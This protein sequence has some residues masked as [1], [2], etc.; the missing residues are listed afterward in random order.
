MSAMKG[1]NLR[2][3]KRRFE[4]KTGVDLN[5][6]YRVRRGPVRKI[7]LLAAVIV[8]CAAM[9]A[10]ASPLFTPLDGDELSLKG[11]YEGNGIV[12]V[13]VENRSDKKLEFQS[14]T[15]LMRWATSEEVESLGGEAVFEN[16]EFAP[17]SSG[18]MTVDLSRAYDVK[19]LEKSVTN[20][21]WFYLVLTN[22]DFLFGHDWMCSVNFGKTENGPLREETR[23]H[24]TAEAES[25]EEVPVQLRFYFEDAYGD[26]LFAFNEANFQY[27]QKVEEILARFPGTVVSA[28]SPDIM[29][30]MPSVFLDPEPMMGKIPGDVLFDEAVPQE[31]QYLLSWSDWTYTDGYGRMVASSDE[32]AWSQVA[33]LPQQEGQSD[34]GVALPLIF[35]FVYDADLALPENYAFIYGAFHSF[36]ELEQHLVRRDEH[37]AIYDATDL[38]YTDLDAYIDY[39]LATR[40]DVFCDESIRARV[41]RI[42]EFYQDRQQLAQLI[43][44]LE[45]EKKDPP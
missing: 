44:Y 45:L 17:H 29:V 31:Q 11:T 20:A 19:A 32:K 34:G 30:G 4:E 28:L 37:Y 8:C 42:Y 3:I 10:F 15:K 18:V 12:S 16:T 43:G 36:A 7:A 23:L 2:N 33:V 39:F 13:F 14:K 40:E 5:A 26:T 25:A 35:L 22:K 41:H 6:A 1:K 21:E 9:L 24:V 38:I 27:Q